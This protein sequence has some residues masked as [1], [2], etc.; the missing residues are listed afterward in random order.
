MSSACLLA[1]FVVISS[2][3]CACVAVAG[4]SADAQTVPAQRRIAV[5]V[6]RLSVSDGDTRQFSSRNH[7][8]VGISYD[9]ATVG[10]AGRF[11]VGP[12]LDVIFQAS[13][14]VNTGPITSSDPS[15]GASLSFTIREQGRSQGGGLGVTGRFLL[16]DAAKPRGIVPYIGG[17]L[18]VYRMQAKYS[19]STVDV[20]QSGNYPLANF[21]NAQTVSES[22]IG[23]GGKISVG[24]QTRAGIFGE[25][26]YHFLPKFRL[27]DG[28]TGN[29][30]DVNL[31][32]FGAR[33][34]YRF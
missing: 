25:V 7:S 26:D 3:L 9:A 31:N 30:L 18:G 4:T 2:A 21:N 10:K 14:T 22:T 28:N 16:A 33:L 20:T 17:A 5:S 1:R 24:L 12:Y 19:V 15:T 32:G 27:S 8:I 29:Y 34:G 23:L 11:V 6:G 13:Q